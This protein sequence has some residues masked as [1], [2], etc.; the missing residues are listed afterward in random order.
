MTT[1]EYCGKLFQ[2]KNKRGPKPKFCSE[3][4]K[5]KKRRENAPKAT[6]TAPKVGL[7]LRDVINV[8]E[9]NLTVKQIDVILEAFTKARA[10]AAR[11]ERELQHDDGF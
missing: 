8:A 5:Q 6:S 7:T 11:R 10:R 1:C 3:S 9:L 2:A 4:C